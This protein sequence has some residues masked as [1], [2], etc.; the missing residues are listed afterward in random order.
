[1]KNCINCGK[2]IP[3]ERLEVLPNTEFCI[4]CAEG[5]VSKFT[6]Y[7]PPCMDAVTNGLYSERDFSDF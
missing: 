7:K 3:K 4:K 2:S 1:M 5:N 6:T